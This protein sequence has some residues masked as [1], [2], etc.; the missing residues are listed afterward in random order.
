[1]PRTDAWE[2]RCLDRCYEDVTSLKTTA[3][4]STTPEHEEYFSC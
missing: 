3:L 2:R 4:E 1:V